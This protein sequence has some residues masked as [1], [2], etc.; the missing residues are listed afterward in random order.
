ML[1]SGRH[2]RRRNFPG[3]INT[4][5]ASDIKNNNWHLQFT[6]SCP[7][8]KASNNGNITLSID[9][10][11]QVIIT[12]KAVG[13]VGEIVLFITWSPTCFS[14][15]YL[16]ENS[17]ASLSGEKLVWHQHVLRSTFYAELKDRFL[18]CLINRFNDETISNQC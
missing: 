15:Y 14:S 16:F 2:L 17:I 11:C 7:S 18:R 5:R 13:R 9:F 8:I 6:V 10:L 12:S 4:F 3:K 1:P